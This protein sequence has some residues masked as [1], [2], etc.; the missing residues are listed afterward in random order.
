MLCHCLVWWL[1]LF[2]Q[3]LILFGHYFTLII[4]FCFCLCLIPL[5]NV[6]YRRFYEFRCVDEM[7]FW[8]A[9]G[10]Y[11]LCRYSFF[12]CSHTLRYT[13]PIENIT[14]SVPMIKDR[15]IYGLFRCMC[16][17]TKHLASSINRHTDKAELTISEWNWKIAQKNHLSTFHAI[18]NILG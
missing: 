12:L 7:H 3:S 4:Y 16:Q 11:Y 8:Y 17:H 14:K 15:K 18:I 5:K 10:W 6:H 2:I 13:N 1:L 9:G